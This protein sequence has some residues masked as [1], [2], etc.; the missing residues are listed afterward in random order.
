VTG[1]PIFTNLFPDEFGNVPCD[2]FEL[3]DDDDFDAVPDGIDLCPQTPPDAL[4]DLD[5]CACFEVDSDGDGV[6][7]CV[8]E[9]PLEFGDYAFGCP[10]DVFDEDDD[11]VND[12]FDAC[13]GT[14][15]GDDVDGDGC[16]IIVV[17]EPPSS[18]PVF[19][20][21]GNFSTLTMALTFGTLVT[22]RLARRRYS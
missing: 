10:C 13:P 5:G 1:E 16:E 18:F 4:V 20:T 2:A 8:D 9:C 3:W 14:P 17:V 15:L 22:L 11:G 19:I 21:C 6:D 12:C 7:D